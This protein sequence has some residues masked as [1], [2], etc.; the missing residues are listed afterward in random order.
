MTEEQLDES[1]SK[2]KTRTLN[3]SGKNTSTG[4]SWKSYSVQDITA[5]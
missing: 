1:I 4:V 3:S 2:L 5:D